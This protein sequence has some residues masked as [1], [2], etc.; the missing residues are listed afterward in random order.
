SASWIT[1][2]SPVAAATPER[3]AAPL[4]R[5]A[6]CRTT[7]SS[8]PRRC[9]SS[10]T[11][12]EPSVEASSIAISSHWS[13]TA[14]TRSTTCATVP[15][16]LYTGMTTLRRKPGALLL[17]DLVPAQLAVQG[18]R[19]DAQDLGGA[20]LVAAFALEHPGDVGPLDHLAC[21]VGV[22]PLGDQRLRAV[23]GELRPPPPA[24]SAL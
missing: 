4:P 15:A 21:G 16:S 3:T 14:R 5:F 23:P 1:T 11:W 10:S 7:W 6:G 20:C 13:G 9:R 17:T 22:R 2:T 24:F 12:P 8:R 19:V 18:R